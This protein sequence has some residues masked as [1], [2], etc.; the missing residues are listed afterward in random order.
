MK[1]FDHVI[2]ID[3]S[4]KELAI[5]RRD[6]DGVETLW[7]AVNL[8]DA[9]AEVAAPAG[10]WRA[11]GA[12]LDAAQETNGRLQLGPWQTALLQQA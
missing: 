3:A 7:V 11:L 9:V 8:S 6:E 10:N 5:L 4:T 2:R 1:N 12:D